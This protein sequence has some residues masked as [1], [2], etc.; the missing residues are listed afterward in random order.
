MCS[1]K[2]NAQ[3]LIKLSL[4][5]NNCSPCPSKGWMLSPFA[6]QGRMLSPTRYT[7]FTSKQ[8]VFRLLGKAGR[9]VLHQ[10]SCWHEFMF[11]CSHP[12]NSSHNHL[13]RKA[14]CSVLRQARL[15]QSDRTS[16]CLLIFHY[17]SFSVCIRTSQQHKSNK[18]KTNYPPLHVEQDKRCLAFGR[19]LLTCFGS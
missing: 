14:G 5:Q 10:V 15:H 2:Q 4:H 19:G 9:S 8:H 6:S 12:Y 7:E 11:T 3:S 1:A 13:P 16:M 17:I 18:T